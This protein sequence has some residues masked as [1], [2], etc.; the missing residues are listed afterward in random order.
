MASIPRRAQSWTLKG[1]DWSLSH[2]PFAH[3][4][5]FLSSR[6]PRL[7]RVQNDIGGQMYLALHGTTGLGDELTRECI[8]RGIAK[9]NVNKAVLAEYNQHLRSNAATL[10]LTELMERG[11]ELVQR[12]VEAQIDVC[13]SAG[14]ADK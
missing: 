6:N 3:R 9:V 2:K 4:G 14:R 11:V 8:R 1:E 7:S 13:M 12:G 5:M 10:P